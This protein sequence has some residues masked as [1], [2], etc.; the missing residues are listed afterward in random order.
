[1]TYSIIQPPFTLKFREM[2]KQELKDYFKWFFEVLPERLCELTEAVR[3]SPGFENWRPDGTPDSLNTLGEWFATHVE[4]RPR[5]PEELSEIAGR[6]S[7]PIEVSRQELT[8]RTFSLAIDVGMYFS[9]VLLK[10][11]SSLNWKQPFGNKRDIDYGQPVLFGRSPVPFNPVRMMVTHAYGLADKT[12][13][14]KELR[15]IYDIWSKKLG[16]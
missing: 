13:S 4:T 2:S 7:F 16:A 14:G 5:T 6:G 12:R 3:Q 11:D 8:N 15:E 10:N 1:M 9:Q